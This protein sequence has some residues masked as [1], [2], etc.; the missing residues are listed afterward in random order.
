MLITPVAAAI[1]NWPPPFPAVIAQL[2]PAIESPVVAT[3]MIAFPVPVFS[4]IEAVWLP[5]IA[6]STSVTVTVTVIVSAFAP[7][8]T[9]RTTTQTLAS[10]PAPHPGAS[11]LGAV[12]N[13]SAPLFATMLN[14]S[15]STE[16][17]L[18]PTAT[19]E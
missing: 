6:I 11:K 12:A 10:F 16:A 5:V 7:S 4:A 14:K 19:I 2:L 9:E 15:W 18:F 17:A 3:V 8:V 1:A 13:D